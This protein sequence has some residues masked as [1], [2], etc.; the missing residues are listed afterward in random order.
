MQFEKIYFEV[1]GIVHRARKDFY[2]KLWEREDWDQEGMLVLYKLLCSFPELEEDKDKLCSYFKV[3]F[4]NRVRDVVRRQESHKRKFDRMPHED[5]HDLSHLVK[6]PG[7][8]N[9]DFI[10][11]RDMLRTYR[12]QLSAEQLEK[13]EKLITGQSFHGRRNMI[14]ELQD[15]LRDFK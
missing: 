7:L 11:L 3:Q 5:I 12:S 13:Y 10:I 9:D 1:Q 15:Y 6:S 14:R 8:L 2:V 4:R